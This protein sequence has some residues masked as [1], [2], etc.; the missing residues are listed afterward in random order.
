MQIQCNNNNGFKEAAFFYMNCNTRCTYS[1]QG[2]FTLWLAYYFDSK[3]RK[4]TVLNRPCS[5]LSNTFQRMLDSMVTCHQQMHLCFLWWALLKDTTQTQDDYVT[6]VW[7]LQ[8]VDNRWGY[9]IFSL[10]NVDSAY[11][12]IT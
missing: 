4:K 7:F 6:S 3:R 5:W 2:R 1:T 10:Q 9:V 12:R 11:W 8:V